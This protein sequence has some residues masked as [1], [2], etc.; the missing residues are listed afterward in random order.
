MQSS[1]TL[2]KQSVLHSVLNLSY[3]NTYQ[4]QYIRNHS[5][6]HILCCFYFLCKWDMTSLRCQS[7][8]FGLHLCFTCMGAESRNAY[9]GYIVCKKMLTSGVK[10]GTVVLAQKARHLAMFFWQCFNLA[11]FFMEIMSLK[12]VKEKC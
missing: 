12:K 3:S 8:E 10:P 4:S 1:K 7:L 5:S 11:D 6:N 2:Q 9:M